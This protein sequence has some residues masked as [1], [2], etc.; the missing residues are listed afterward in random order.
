MDFV[1]QNP[2]ERDSIIQLL[3]GKAVPGIVRI[4]QNNSPD[5]AAAVENTFDTD[6]HLYRNNCYHFAWHF[7]MK[8]LDWLPS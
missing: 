5:F 7:Y 1:P 8:S 2:E 4:K 6:L 3:L